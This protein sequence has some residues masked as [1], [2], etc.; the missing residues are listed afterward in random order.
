MRANIAPLYLTMVGVV[1]ALVFGSCMV[2]PTITEIADTDPIFTAVAL[3]V[4]ANLEEFTRTSTVKPEN[5]TVE[6]LAADLPIR[7][8][9]EK[10]SDVQLGKIIFTERAELTN[11]L[12]TE[13]T[14]YRKNTEFI[15]TWELRNI[16]STVWTKNYQI[17]FFSGDR[18]GSGLPTQYKLGSNINPGET[19][20]IS[21]KMLTSSASGEYHSIWVLANEKGTYFFPL[22]SWIK[23]DER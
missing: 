12:P 16:G 10:P 19:I 18:I 5:L 2:Q 17:L 1:T 6:K 23:V 21:V 7:E 15:T 13:F 22:N 14:N 11:Q 9:Q 8:T 20:K 3:T 4:R